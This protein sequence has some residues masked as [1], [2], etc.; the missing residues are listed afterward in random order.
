MGTDVAIHSYE[1]Q[2]SVRKLLR[3][4]SH[5]GVNIC[6]CLMSISVCV[7]CRYLY[8][9]HVDICMCLMSISVCVSCR[10]Y[11]KILYKAANMVCSVTILRPLLSQHH[12][13]TRYTHICN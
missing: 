3:E 4:T 5:N 7:S 13:I 12:T 11:Q 8:V 2:M 9:S 1:V 10:S 6:M